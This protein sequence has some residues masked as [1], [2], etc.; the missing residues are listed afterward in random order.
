MRNKQKH[1]QWMLQGEGQLALLCTEH[2][3]GKLPRPWEGIEM[4][5]G[6]SLQ[7]KPKLQLPRR[8]AGAS[9]STSCWSKRAGGRSDPLA[10]FSTAKAMWSDGVPDKFICPIQAY[11]AQTT[12]C[13]RILYEGTA[14]FSVP[15][16][17]VQSV[18]NLFND[19]VD[20]VLNNDLSGHSEFKLG[21]I[22]G[23]LAW[24]TLIISQSSQTLAKELNTV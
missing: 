24:L 7:G 19:S 23:S 11:Y 8:G 13:V 9:G 10:P 6:G 14:S 20:W 2:N 1:S 15:A 22:A 17:M 5:I 12:T 16:L 3:D 18:P 4:H 21:D